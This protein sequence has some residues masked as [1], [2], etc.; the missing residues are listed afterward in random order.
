MADTVCAWCE[1]EFGVKS[2]DPQASHGMCARHALEWA[3]NLEKN[4]KTA[5][6]P[7]ELID[8]RLESIR[9]KAQEPGSAAPDMAETGVPPDFVKV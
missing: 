5:N 4:M 2:P 9:Q 6:V 8:K 1:Q 7:Q 3:D